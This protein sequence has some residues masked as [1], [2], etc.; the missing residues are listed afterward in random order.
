MIYLIVGTNAYRVQHEL[1]QLVKSLG[2]RL[3]KI[4]AASLDLNKLADTVRGLNLF[5]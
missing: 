5:Q 3:E 1:Q 2:V 4:D